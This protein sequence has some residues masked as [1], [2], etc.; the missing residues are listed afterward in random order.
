MYCSWACLLRC[1][2]KAGQREGLS[3]KLR[4]A[5]FALP[6]LVGISSGGGSAS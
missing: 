2:D 5:S 4:R 3:S 6:H 1:A